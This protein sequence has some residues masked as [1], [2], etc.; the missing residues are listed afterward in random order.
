VFTADLS[1]ST[2]HLFTFPHFSTT[3][4]PKTLRCGGNGEQAVIPL[5]HIPIPT[6]RGIM[7]AKSMNVKIK[8]A[9]SPAMFPP[10][11]DCWLEDDPAAE[12]RSRKLHFLG[13]Q[14]ISYGTNSGV[15]QSER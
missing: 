9:L 3:S 14:Q 15:E 13:G 6:R 8:I 12:V 1:S 5:F 7:S 10:E 11:T 2:P 4:S